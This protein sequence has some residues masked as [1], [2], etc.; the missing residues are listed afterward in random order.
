MMSIQFAISLGAL[1]LLGLSYFCR[2]DLSQPLLPFSFFWCLLLTTFVAVLSVG[3]IQVHFDC[4][5]LWGECYAHGYPNW[6]WMAK[7][8]LLLSPSLWSLLAIG[9]AAN[10]FWK[11]VSE[12]RHDRNN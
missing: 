6:L 8:L 5:F 11:F 3:L 1:V 2:R 7:P 10:N 9:F 4:M 12:R